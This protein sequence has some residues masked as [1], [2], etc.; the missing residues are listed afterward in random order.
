[1]NKKNLKGNGYTFNGEQLFLQ[2]FGIKYIYIFLAF[3]LTSGEKTEKA[4]HIIFSLRLY[5]QPEN[6]NL[7]S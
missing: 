5:L 6:Q 3:L 2:S 1:M 7:Q 4:A